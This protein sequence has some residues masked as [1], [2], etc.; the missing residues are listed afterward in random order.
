[1][2]LLNDLPRMAVEWLLWR[3]PCEQKPPILSTSQTPIFWTPG[4]CCNSCAASS[5]FNLAMIYDM[6]LGGWQRG[7]QKW[8]RLT[9][10]PRTPKRQSKTM[11]ICIYIYIFKQEHHSGCSML[12]LYTHVCFQYLVYIYI[13]MNDYNYIW[14]TCTCQCVSWHEGKQWKAHIPQHRC[15]RAQSA[16]KSVVEAILRGPKDTWHV[17]YMLANQD[18]CFVACGCISSNL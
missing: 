1:M 7:H 14:Y 18:I 17:L 15:I 12:L 3:L 2:T 4:S 10:K 5:V 9:V 11:Y 13:Y 6:Q 16:A 8:Q